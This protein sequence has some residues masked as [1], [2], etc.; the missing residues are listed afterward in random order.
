V[1]SAGVL[2]LILSSG[3]ASAQTSYVIETVAVE[4]D[5]VEGTPLPL[6]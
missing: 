1:L 2:A 3:Q 5:L 4:G 6:L